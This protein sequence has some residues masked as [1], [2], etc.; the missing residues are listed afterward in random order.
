VDRGKSELLVYVNGSPVGGAQSLADLKGSCA[1]A[2]AL[3]VGS[4]GAGG[5]FS[6]LV[7]DFRLYNKALSGAEVKSLA[8]GK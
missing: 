2:A 6:G 1:S 7:D 4:L 3:Y 5:F 8:S